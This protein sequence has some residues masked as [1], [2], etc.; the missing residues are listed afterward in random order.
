MRGNKGGKISNSGT[1]AGGKPGTRATGKAALV[2]SVT[3]HNRFESLAADCGPCQDQ[4]TAIAAAQGSTAAV[5]ALASGG[6]TA[7]PAPAVLGTSPTA[8]SAA[9]N[10]A[11]APAAAPSAAATPAAAGTTA[12]T[13]AASEAA[14]AAPTLLQDNVLFSPERQ[15]DSSGLQRRVHDLEQQTEQLR[16]AVDALQAALREQAAAMAAVQAELASVKHQSAEATTQGQ[17]LKALLTKMGVTMGAEAQRVKQAIDHGATAYID[18]GPI[19]QQLQTLQAAADESAQRCTEIN[20]IKADVAKLNSQQQTDCKGTAYAP[21]DMTAEQVKDSIC[22]AA[23]ISKS[24]MH[25]SLAYKPEP[26]SATAAAAGAGSSSPGTGSN[27]PAGAGTSNNSSAA[28]T[29]TSGSAAGPGGNAAN[30]NTRSRPLM[31]VWQLHVQNRALLATVLGGRTRRALKQ[32]RQ[33]VYVDVHLTMEQRQ[34][35]KRLQALR[36]QL[37]QAGTQTR[38]QGAVLQQRT[39]GAGGRYSWQEVAYPGPPDPSEDG[40][41]GAAADRGSDGTGDTAGGVGGAAA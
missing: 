28:E 41:A 24:A 34:Q 16:A 12:I 40:G 14:A 4:D 15:Q 27:G 25:V 31:A 33:P 39:R 5:S 11:A 32:A 29:G 38:W 7:N 1:G 20:R 18:M 8:P 26:H 13:A 36:K 9:D 10:A 17:Q 37:Q 2:K 30:G 23:G 6:A 22:T 3:D 21:A 19:K 35:R